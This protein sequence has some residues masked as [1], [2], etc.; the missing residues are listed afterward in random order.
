[1]SKEEYKNSTAPTI[2]HFYEKLLLLKDRM[3]TQTGKDMAAERHRF[4]K[5]YLDQFY[6]E[7][8]GLR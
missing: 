2:N 7:W 6:A 3:N 1:M 4:M 5:T 8:D